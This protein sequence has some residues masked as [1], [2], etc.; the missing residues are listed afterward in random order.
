MTE[1]QSPNT[2]DLQGVCK[3]YN[4]GSVKII[5]DLNLTIPKNSN[6]NFISIIGPSGCGKSTV[7]RFISGIDTPTKGQAL[8]N[9]APASLKNSVGQVFQQYSSFEW[10]TVLK[11]V[12][13]GLQYQGGSSKEERR[14]RAMDIIKRVGLEGHEHKY[15]EYPKLSGGQL[16]RV[17]IARS[18][19]A[20]PEIMLM[21]EPFGALDVKTRNSMQR[22]VNELF[23]QYK[24]T[25]LFVTHD[26]A[27]AVYLSDTIYVMGKAPSKFI[28]KVD[29]QLPYERDYSIKRSSSFHN[30]VAELE[31]IMMSME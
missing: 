13:M 6:G 10:Y 21:D 11:N 2:I 1:N 17:A 30:Y 18:I 7:L 15:A 29:I 22:M 28:E 16:Q 20:N 27:E 23:K 9:G 8:V 25:I 19:L 26:I 24:S 14:E 31:D 5:E 3:Y 4:N 12:Q